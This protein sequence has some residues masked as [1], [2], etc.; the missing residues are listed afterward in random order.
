M[1]VR[2][3]A[4]LLGVFGA[5]G[6][7]AAALLYLTLGRVTLEPSSTYYLTT[8][9]ASGLTTGD[10][11]RIAGVRVGRVN[12]ISIG[13]HNLVSVRFSLQRSLHLTDQTKAVVRYQNLLGDR[14]LELQ[15]PN[16]VGHVEPAGST[17]P[18]SRTVPALDLDVLLNGF[19]PLFAGLQPSQI[20]ELATNVV[21]T[22][23]GQG[24]T[25]Q[26]LLAQTASL[27]NTVADRDQAIGSLITN[28]D[29]VLG[30][31]DQ[32]D[33]ELR[34]TITNFQTLLGKLNTDKTPILNA[35]DQINS[36]STS[37]AGLLTAARPPLKGTIADTNSLATMLNQNTDS[38]QAMLTDVPKAY[39]AQTNA[40]THGSF[41]N[42]Y[43]C[44]LRIE[45]TGANGKPTYSP[46]FG[47]NS[48]TERCQ[49]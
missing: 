23:Q 36:M 48:S 20:N 44:S 26:D 46:I 35:V 27:T 41:F 33:H 40:G 49:K 15:Q 24:G 17:I 18:P 14:F 12:G 28:L 25:V 16:G 8:A 29:S 1:R 11:V 6:L 38:L 13:K 2:R 43:L 42:F 37:V 21:Q 31:V 45:L 22:L 47:S 32:R 3:E 9:N 34:S 19:K 10:P 4:I 39:Q 7:L 30:D 5:V